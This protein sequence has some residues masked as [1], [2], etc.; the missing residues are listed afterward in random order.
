M[1]SKSIA[2]LTYL[3]LFLAFPFFYFWLLS[4]H[5]LTFLS[6]SETIYPVI[7]LYGIGFAFFIEKNIKILA[8]QE[9]KKTLILLGIT[10]L[11]IYAVFLLLM[12]W[13]R[14]AGF[15]SESIDIVYFHQTIW[16]LSEFKI[17]YLWNL[18][19]QLFPIWSQHFSPILIF[20]VP[21][22]WIDRSEGL[23]FMLQAIAVISG[24]FPI[25]AVSKQ[26]LKSRSIGIAM[27]WA[28][29]S[30]GGLQYGIGY[31]FHEILFF[32]VLFLWS[33]YFYLCK[34]PKLYLLFILLSLFVKEE[35]AFITLFW[36]IYLFI[37]KRDRLIGTITATLGIAW[38]FLCFNIIFPYFN[39]GGNFG[40][41]G[42][43]D[44]RGGT[45]F[46]GIVTSALL[47]PFSFLKTLVTPE[48]KVQMMLM[49]FGQFAFLLFLF[50]PTLIIIFPSLMEKLLSSSIAMAN[51]AHYSA[52]IAAVT[53]V[54]TF[55]ALPQI[56]RYKLVTRYIQNKTIFFTMLIF[57]CALFSTVFFG[58]NG[59]SLI[60][61]ARAS[62]YERGL[63]DDNYQL[64]MQIVN[65]LP[66]NATVSAQ[67]QIAPHLNRYYKN[68]T[69]W[70]GMTGT[71]DFVIIDTQLLPVLGGTMQSY[72]NA[73]E[74]LNKNKNY[75]LA[76]ANTG[77]FVYRR[78]S[79]TQ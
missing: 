60:P 18:N 23:L 15:I 45:G 2:S 10:C 52:A 56:Y 21:F 37:I 1:T 65:N 44:T 33:Y 64:L 8:L 59:Y 35:V 42:Q 34:K 11:I 68:V 12:T 7:F 19:Q 77:I 47:K 39:H 16:Q 29:L 74:K 14:Y 31:G 32:P 27:S 38:Y 61:S 55:E 62:I 70:P 9:N 30:F 13:S 51:G 50:P 63:A 53:V 22:Y 6:S 20:L 48:I 76:V 54:A 78:K 5:Q 79:Y 3:I 71:E 49:T 67:Y 58:Y 17:P 25:Y 26:L 57:S 4:T 36:G 28:Y 40:Y 41:W 73:L 46:L 66:A 24:A 75:Q 43:Y 72:S 69:T